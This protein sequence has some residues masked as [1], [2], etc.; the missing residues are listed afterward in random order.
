M[1]E[2]DEARQDTE[3][4]FEENTQDNAP[5]ETEDVPQDLQPGEDVKIEQ[6]E[7]DAAK[8]VIDEAVNAA[9]A[10]SAAAV[11][12]DAQISQ[13]RE[14]NSQLMQQN[15]QLQEGYQSLRQQ[16]QQMSDQQKQSIVNQVYEQPPEKPVIDFASLAFADEDEIKQKQDEY[17]DAMAQYVKRG[18]MDELSPFVD[19]AKRGRME[20]EKQDVIAALSKVPE[21]SGIKDLVPQMDRIIENNSILNNDAIPMDEKYINAYA[22]A[23]GVNSI[24]TPKKEPTAEDLMKIYENNPEFQELVE[25]KRLQDVKKNQQVPHMSASSGAV[26][27]ALNIQEKPKTWD[28]ASE[29]TRKMFGA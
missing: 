12:M 5:E 3:R 2:F 19:E 27:A 20:R 4:M 11:N 9:E 25:Q 17:A 28:D 22:I 1:A 6:E 16:I 18:I 29:R 23:R 21:L 24:N 13:L 10:A 26:N 15:N 8:G 7:M 14:Q